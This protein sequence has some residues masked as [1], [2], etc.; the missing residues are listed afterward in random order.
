M[1]LVVTEIKNRI[2]DIVRNGDPAS[3]IFAR[4]ILGMGSSNIDLLGTETQEGKPK[5]RRDPDYSFQHREARWAGVVLEL[6]YPLK[7]RALPHLAD[8]YL[9][10]TDGNIRI[11]VGIDLDTYTKKGTISTWQPLFK[12]DDRGVIV[13]LEAAL[14]IDE[15][16]FRDRYGNPNQD[17]ESGLH[18]DLEDFGPTDLTVDLES[19]IP[20]FIDS[21]TLC[22]FLARAEAAQLNMDEAR[23]GIPYQP[24][25]LKIRK[26]RREEMESNRETSAEVTA[27]DDVTSGD[28]ATERESVVSRDIETESANVAS[29]SSPIKGEKAVS[30]DEEM[31]LRIPNPYEKS[32]ED[33]A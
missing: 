11:L 1:A 6:C 7:R 27:Y 21:A 3:R 33:I 23:G 15:E 29:E 18:L 9:L 30:G 10:E 31:P 24:K 8:D 25:S 16:V 20:I 17:P 5:M 22:L 14:V 13:E 4:E 2:D 32:C 26:R 28:K 12:K 19:E